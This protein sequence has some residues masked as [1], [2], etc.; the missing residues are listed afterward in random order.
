MTTRPA[1]LRLILLLTLCVALVVLKST[2]VVA[3]VW[4]WPEVLVTSIA[5]GALLLH[6][7]AEIC[8][9]RW[10]GSVDRKEPEKN[11]VTSKDKNTT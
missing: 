6:T 1:I 5:I 4:F 9:I 7:F 8:K 2:L 10:L 3:E 11:Q